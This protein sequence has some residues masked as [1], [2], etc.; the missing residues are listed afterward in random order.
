[1][2]EKIAVITGTSSGIGLLS[3][4]ELAR[5][6]FRVVASMRDLGRRDRL[7]QAASTA[8]RRRTPQHPPPRRH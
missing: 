7:D 6:G 8:G 4:I 5:N 2:S 3:A 1:M